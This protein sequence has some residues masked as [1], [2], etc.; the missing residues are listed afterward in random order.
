MS[1]VPIRFPRPVIAWY[2]SA[3]I[4]RQCLLPHHIEYY[5]KA[6]IVTKT[7]NH[8][9]LPRFAT[10]TIPSPNSF[11]PAQHEISV[12]ELKNKRERNDSLLLLD[13]REP[14]EYQIAHLEGSILIPLNE[15]PQQVNRLDSNLET[16]VYCHHGMRSLYAAAYL[17][18]NGFQNVK[19]LAGGIDQWAIEIDPT[20]SRY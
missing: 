19:S 2:C 10:R 7:I 8:S 13:V 4:T 3:E 17:Y 11:Q 9:N 14:I 12:R 18:Q 20:L 1:S 15:L 16:V 6:K 5:R